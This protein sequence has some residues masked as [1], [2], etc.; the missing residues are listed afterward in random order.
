MI[1]ILM[2]EQMAIILDQ[3]ESRSLKELNLLVLQSEL[4]VFWNRN[5][6]N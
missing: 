5:S 2:C 1:I 4:V 6:G 3:I